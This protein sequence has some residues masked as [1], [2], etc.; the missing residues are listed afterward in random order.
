MVYY[1]PVQTMINAPGVAEVIINVIVQYY[2]F[3]DLIVS[4]QGSVFALKF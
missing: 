2:G 3:P 4:N 1:E